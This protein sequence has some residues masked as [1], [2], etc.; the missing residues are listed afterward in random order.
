MKKAF[1]S[2]LLM[3]AVA[4]GTLAAQ[5]PAPAAGAPQATQPGAQNPGGGRGERGP[6][7]G[8]MGGMMGMGGR[9]LTGTVTAVAAGHYTVKSDEGE[10]W[11][12]QFSANTHI[13]HQTAR[14]DGE[15]EGN[16]RVGPGGLPPQVIKATDIKVGDAVNVVGEADA[17]KKSIG[18]VVVLQVDAEVA[19]RIREMKANFGKTWLMG[20]VTAID[21]VKVTLNS[22]V[23][24]AAHAFVADENTTF[25]ERRE[26]IT[27]GDVKVGDMVRADGAIKDGKFVAASVRVMGSPQGDPAMVPRNAHRPAPPQ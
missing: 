9:G 3:S 19:Q 16:G 17:A 11:T 10:S 20:S 5:D 23:D 13:L 2:I 22:Q 18:A 4:A 21:G 8:G 7:G 26:P 27:L 15:G 12:V 1:L 6:R 24:G 25:R 14:R